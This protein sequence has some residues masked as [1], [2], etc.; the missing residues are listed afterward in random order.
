MLDVP[1]ND[2]VLNASLQNCPIDGALSG[3][4]REIVL[5]SSKNALFQ[6]YYV[7]VLKQNYFKKQR[8]TSSF[9]LTKGN[10]TGPSDNG[11]LNRLVL[12]CTLVK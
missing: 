6:C 5:E 12:T 4:L 3:Y 1:I 2:L 11:V 10:N 7:Y 9:L 8:F